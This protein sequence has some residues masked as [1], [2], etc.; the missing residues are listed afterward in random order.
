MDGKCASSLPRPCVC[1]PR[2]SFVDLDCHIRHAL[3]KCL[4]VRI[5]S[6]LRVP[7]RARY[8]ESTIGISRAVW[9]RTAIL[10]RELVLACHSYGDWD[11]P[12]MLSNVKSTSHR[13]GYEFWPATVTSSIAGFVGRILDVDRIVIP[14]S[15]QVHAHSWHLRTA[16]VV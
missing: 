14:R 12:W 15:R 10:P 3:N 11:E 5:A 13:A 6:V 1:P 4:C 16:L 9:Y 2:H 7:V 8:P